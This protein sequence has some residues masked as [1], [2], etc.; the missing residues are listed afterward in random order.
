[1]NIAASKKQL[2]HQSFRNSFQNPDFLN[3]NNALY[4]FKPKF[5]IDEKEKKKQLSPTNRCG[6][7]RP[8][9]MK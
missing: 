4:L 5:S 8:T 6:H 1:M 9:S 3:K 2:V 7:K